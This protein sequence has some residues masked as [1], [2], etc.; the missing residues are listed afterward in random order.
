M[1]MVP[2]ESVQHMN[3]T[4]NP[5]PSYQVS[6]ERGHTWLTDLFG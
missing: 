2:M 1:G 6:E 5:A 4:L 3:M